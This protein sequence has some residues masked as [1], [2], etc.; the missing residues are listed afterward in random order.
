MCSSTPRKGTDTSA[1]V[2]VPLEIPFPSPSE[3]EVAGWREQWELRLYIPSKK[4]QAQS[5][6]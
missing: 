6:V 2:R 1:R 3:P 4:A 5:T